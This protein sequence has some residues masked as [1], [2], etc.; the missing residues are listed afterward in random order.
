M[1]QAVP[2][3]CRWMSAR[4][5]WRLLGQGLAIT[6][7]K[8]GMQPHALSAVHSGATRC[9]RGSRR[10]F[11]CRERGML[12]LLRSSATHRVGVVTALGHLAEY[13]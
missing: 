12:C 7:K 6:G 5:I 1:G 13:E 4:Q 3:K 8:Q 11:S 9:I 10:C 2:S